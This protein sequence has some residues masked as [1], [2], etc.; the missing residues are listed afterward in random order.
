MGLKGLFPSRRVGG[1]GGQLRNNDPRA[2]GASGYLS[3][4]SWLKEMKPTTL[5]KLHVTP[6]TLTPS[7]A[8]DSLTGSGL[9]LFKTQVDAASSCVSFF[10]TSGWCS[11]APPITPIP[12]DPSGWQAGRTVVVQSWCSPDRPKHLVHGIVGMLWVNI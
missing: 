9:P 6:W 8:A 4:I 5:L 3:R 11:E 10:W 7:G 12:T 2:I 1:L